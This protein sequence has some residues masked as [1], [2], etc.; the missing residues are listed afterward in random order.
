M[1]NLNGS[2]TGGGIGGSLFGD[3]TLTKVFVGG[4][5]WETHRDTMSSYFQQFGEI[6][7]AVVITD[8]NTG[9]SKGYGFVTFRDPEAARKACAD[10]T[11][12]IDGRRTNCNLASL[13]ARPRPSPSPLG[14]IHFR[15]VHPIS[16]ASTAAGGYVPTP[17]F[18]QTA[19]Q[20]AYQQGLYAYPSHYGFPAYS[21][22][23]AYQQSLYNPYGGTQYAAIYAGQGA[24]A[25]PA[26]YTYSAYSQPLQ[27]SGTT[28]APPQAYAVPS[29]HL[30]QYS[31]TGYAG[32]NAMPQYAGYIP[33]AAA[34]SPGYSVQANPSP[35]QGQDTMQQLTITDLSSQQGVTSEQISG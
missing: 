2:A 7:E 16:T 10:P 3:T 9:R 30:M 5:A 23:Y 6:L 20:Y 11:P 18:P 12:V 24:V 22:D 8:K 21:P 4:L 35:N 28:Y 32:L 13:G 27:Y 34:P 33:A 29:P 31:P 14:G 15:A 19:A 26:V 17:M 25:N 1:T